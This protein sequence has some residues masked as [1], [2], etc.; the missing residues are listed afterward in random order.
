MQALAD[1]ISGVLLLNKPSGITSNRALQICKR[2]IKVKKAGHAGTL[3]P[4]ATGMLP[5]CIG[6]ATKFSQYLL[7]ANK[8]YTVTAQLGVTTD[9]GD[10]EGVLVSQ[11]AVTDFTRD[12]LLSVLDKFKGD[13]QQIP[14]MYSALK[15]DGKKLYELARQGI[16]VDRKERDVKIINL[17]VKSTTRDSFTLTVTCS[18]G[19]YI[20]SLVEDIGNELGYGA[21]VVQ[22]SRDSIEALPDKMIT[23]E[24]LENLQDKVSVLHPIENLLLDFK[25]ITIDEHNTQKILW[26]QTVTGLPKIQEFNEGETI[27]IFGYREKNK[28]FLGLGEI[29]HN[30][31]LPKRLI[32]L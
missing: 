4:L 2:L 16:T 24:Q 8:T 27:K 20:R 17:E 14:P 9:T 25:D 11:V 26:G 21:H 18:K 15:Q 5:I 13:I 7:G 10:S 30:N 22:L 19:T 6:Q 3:D 12:K 23:I 32:A 28:V 29:S 31:I 1:K